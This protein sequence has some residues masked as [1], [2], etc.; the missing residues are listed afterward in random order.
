MTMLKRDQE[1]SMATLRHFFDTLATRRAARLN[2]LHSVR[3]RRHDTS[4]AKTPE[5]SIQQSQDLLGSIDTSTSWASAIR[6]CSEPGL[7]LPS[8]GLIPI[9][10]TKDNLASRSGE[11]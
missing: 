3:T 6:P 9:E 4:D 5:P 1:P 11:A 8:C 2:S 10:R 7:Y